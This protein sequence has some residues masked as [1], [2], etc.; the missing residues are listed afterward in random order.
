MS[1]ALLFAIN[2]DFETVLGKAVLCRLEFLSE[3]LDIFG[4][5]PRFL[6]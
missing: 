3:L 4:Y 5:L 6:S 1:D 2:Y